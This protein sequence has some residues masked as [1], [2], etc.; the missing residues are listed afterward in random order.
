MD[1]RI[2]PIFITRG[3]CFDP[4]RSAIQKEKCDNRTDQKIRA[5]SKAGVPAATSRT[6]FIGTFDE[7]MF[8]WEAGVVAGATCGSNWA[9]DEAVNGMVG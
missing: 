4:E 6:A 1:E 8:D 7:L 9:C 5:T 3:P 2:C